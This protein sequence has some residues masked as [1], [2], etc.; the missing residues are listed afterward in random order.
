MKSTIFFAVITLLLNSCEKSNYRTIKGPLSCLVIY[1][2]LST[3]G[4]TEHK[5]VLVENY[6][7]EPLDSSRNMQIIKNYLDTAEINGVVTEID[8]LFDDK[9]FDP[10]E[11]TLNWYEINKSN[12]VE[13][14]LRDS[15]L[16]QFS[17][18]DKNGTRCYEGPCW[19]PCTDHE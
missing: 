17:F 4:S 5:I 16:V 15:I 2:N 1:E 19:R 3:I 13:V 14:T 6:P 12:I 10:G 11:P 7:I 18:F 8:F 9:D